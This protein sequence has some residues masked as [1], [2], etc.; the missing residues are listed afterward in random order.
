MSPVRV[1]DLVESSCREFVMF[2]KGKVHAAQDVVR[3]KGFILDKS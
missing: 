3:K 1:Q 2:R